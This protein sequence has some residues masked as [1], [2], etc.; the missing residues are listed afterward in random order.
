MNHKTTINYDRKDIEIKLTEEQLYDIEKKV[1]QVEKF[2]PKYHEK[3]FYVR[4]GVDNEYYWIQTR[5]DCDDF[6][7]NIIQ[8]SSVFRTEKEAD[9]YITYLEALDKYTFKPDWKNFNQYKHYIYFNNVNNKI[10]WDLC[11]SNN[12][13]QIIPYFKS[14]SDIKQF[15]SEVGEDNVKRFMFNIW[16]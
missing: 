2:I 6:D 13:G 12:I 8:N 7:C 1:I 16:N 10:D 3:Y 4:K 14:Q 11:L 5:N 15:I 9:A